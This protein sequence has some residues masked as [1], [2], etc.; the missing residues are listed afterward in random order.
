M[1]AL[2]HKSACVLH[3]AL[4]C[5]SADNEQTAQIGFAT[6]LKLRTLK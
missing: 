1:S 3:D 6:D 4:S 5:R 2:L